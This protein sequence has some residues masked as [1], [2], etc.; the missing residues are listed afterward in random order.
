MRTLKLK[1][2][3]LFQPTPWMNKGSASRQETKQ[4]TLLIDSCNSHLVVP[5]FTIF[6]SMISTSKSVKYKVNKS[7]ST[8]MVNVFS[9]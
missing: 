5:V 7:I 1:T 6:N 4:G 3:S 2:K 9:L 8:K